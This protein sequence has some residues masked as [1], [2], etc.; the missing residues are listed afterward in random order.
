MFNIGKIKYD[1]ITNHEK[2]IDN[3]GPQAD[4]VAADNVL[5][6]TRVASKLTAIFDIFKRNRII[7]D[8]SFDY[9][10]NSWK[11]FILKKY[12]AI[13][14]LKVH[15]N[16]TKVL[17]EIDNFDSIWGIQRVY[18]FDKVN[19]DEFSWEDFSNKLLD[20]VHEVFYNREKAYIEKLIEKS[21]VPE[22]N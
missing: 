12:S 9:C 3:V 10:N 19:E 6:A 11:I 5:E 7:D 8:F 16:G 21:Y 13:C 15:T 22:Q 17:I 4:K 1:I 14:G 18:S 20:Y 2:F